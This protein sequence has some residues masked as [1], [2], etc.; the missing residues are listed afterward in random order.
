MYLTYD[1][2]KELGGELEE[3]PFTLLEYKSRKQIDKYTFG[4]L[5]KGIPENLKQD[6]EKTMMVLMEFNASNKTSNVVSETIDGYS[7]SYGDTEENENK[8]KAMVNDLLEGLEING[9]PLT[10]CG[11]VNDYKRKYYPIS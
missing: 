6:I 5:I 9:V 3:A 4:R 10:Y 1:E 11:G 2:Y 8:I 7:V